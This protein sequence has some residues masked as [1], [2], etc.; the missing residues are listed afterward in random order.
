VYF[1]IDIPRFMM[2]AMLRV[3]PSCVAIMET[4]LWMNFLD[5]S[6][7][8]GAHTMIINGR[9]SDRSFHRS[10]K[11]RA[12]YAD[13][14]KRVDQC[15]MQSEADAERIEALGASKTEV[16]GSSKMDQAADGL[17]A[18]PA[19]WRNELGLSENDFV[20]V[21]GS[22]RGETDEGIVLD[23]LHQSGVDA[24]IIHAPRHIERA[25]ALAARAK[26]KFGE[27]GRRSLGEKSSYT[28]LDTYGE[29][30]SVYCVADVVVIGGGFDNQGGQNLIQPLAHGKPVIHGPY[31]QN[32]RQAVDM[33]H[34][35][36][37]AIKTSTAEEFKTALTDLRSDAEMRKQMGERGAAM[38][39]AQLGASR[40]YAEAIAQAAQAAQKSLAKD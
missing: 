23:W 8:V 34:D 17:D 15:L 2:A 19:H 33:A 13:L 4:E 27:S 26:E 12:F 7:T 31:M 3:Q 10:M 38:V 32:F 6:K 24:K 40:R 35:V 30:G 36:E 28:V 22:T 16:F 1:P 9:V 11:V 21:V 39:Q 5:W 37:A 29:L 25:E 14:L 18:D 20:V